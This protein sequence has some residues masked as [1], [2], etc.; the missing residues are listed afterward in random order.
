M[1]NQNIIQRRGAGS[2]SAS[3]ALPIT[4]KDVAQTGK[5]GKQSSRRRIRLGLSVSPYDR[6]SLIRWSFLVFISI[7]IALLTWKPILSLLGLR[8]E[9]KHTGEHDISSLPDDHRHLSPRSNNLPSSLP[10]SKFTELSLALENSDMVALYFAASWC[11]MSTPISLA[12]DEAF[13]KNDMLLTPGGERKT[14]SVVYVSSD[15]TLDQYNGYL[16][17]RNW[18]SIPFE[19]PQRN[20]LKRHFSTCAH[21]ELDELGMDRKHE[22]PTIIVIDSQTQGVIT[23]SGA[24]DVEQMGAGSLDHWRSMQEWIRKSKADLN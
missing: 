19:S 5:S 8:T 16:H 12:L 7:I 1:P 18:I 2:A 9:H 6:T 22:I 4:I 10:L 14:L 21:R 17:D 3:T 20:Q 24:S 23:T 13:G 15:K 11:P